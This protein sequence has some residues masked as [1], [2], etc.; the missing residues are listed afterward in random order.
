M[1]ETKRAAVYAG[2]FD[3]ITRGHEWVF[4]TAARLFDRVV[5]VV[6]ENPGKTPFIPLEDRLMLLQ[7]V[8]QKHL[9]VSSK[10]QVGSMSGEFV[11]DWAYKNG[12]E[13][14]IRGVRNGSDFEYEQTIR[15]INSDRQP[16]VSS[17]YLIPPRHLS[18]IS[19]S[20]IKGLVGLRGWEKLVR[21]YVSLP[22][23]SYMK[24]QRER[25]PRAR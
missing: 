16:K 21:D 5:V 19:S 22:V 4:A 12:C 7:K 20:T 23:L 2:T 1:K 13:W 14:L 3:P 9:T 24:M 6:A 8:L 11:V 18:E 17:V 10:V 15:H 25:T